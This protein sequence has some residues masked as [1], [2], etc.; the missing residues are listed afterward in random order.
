MR[1]SGCAEFAGFDSSVDTTR[2]ALIARNAANVFEPGT[3]RTDDVEVHTGEPA[4]L[5]IRA[6]VLAAG[7]GCSAHSAGW[8]ARAGL[9][10]LSP[11][12]VPIVGRT[13]VDNLWLNCGHGSKGACARAHVR[14]CIQC[15]P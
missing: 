10:P 7:R 3:F 12:D 8:A 15:C 13:E 5:S 4:C 6:L 11:D 1:L 14:A 9:R 2:T